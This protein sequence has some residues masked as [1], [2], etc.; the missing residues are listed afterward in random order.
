[1]S[2]RLPNGQWALAQNLGPTINTRYK[3]DFPQM[4]P[5]GKTLY[6]SSQGHEGMGDFDLFKSTW[7]EEAN[8]WTEPKNLGYPINTS[9]DDHCISFTQNN[10]IAYISSARPGGYGDL[11]LYRIKFE[12][13]KENFTI[14]KGNIITS[15]S[16]RTLTSLVTIEDL[17][18]KDVPPYTYNPNPKTR[19]FIMALPPSKYK[20]T[21]ESKGYKTF[22]DIFFVF[23]IGISQNEDKK[24]F[25][26]TK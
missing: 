17:K 21:I 1:M 15:D 16:A 20:I 8:T 19:K 6:F 9:G 13:S 4:S 24:T 14:L 25:L 23:E 10:R 22:T 18:N 12:D 5:D 3:E 26:L 7:N 11:D 2:R